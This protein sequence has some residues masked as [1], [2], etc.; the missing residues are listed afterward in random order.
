MAQ[1]PAHSRG[2]T[3]DFGGDHACPQHHPGAQGTGGKAGHDAK[4]SCMRAEVKETDSVIALR[5]S[6]T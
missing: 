5:R 2:S 4:D 6:R 1:R 3:E